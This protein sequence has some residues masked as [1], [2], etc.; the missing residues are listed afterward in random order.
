VG[1]GQPAR[2]ADWTKVS[3]LAPG[4]E[5]TVTTDSR[6]LLLHFVSA[7]ARGVVLLNVS[8][9]PMSYGAQI[10]LARMLVDHPT[11]FA[12]DAT[13]TIIDHNYRLTPERFVERDRPVATRSQLIEYVD[14]RI[15]RK[16][17]RNGK[18]GSYAAR[19]SLI[20]GLVGGAVVFAVIRSGCAPSPDCTGAGVAY[21]PIGAGFGTLVGALIGYS[22]TRDRSIVVYSAP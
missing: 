20:G 8:A 12:L 10:T 13:T 15:V 6:T 19:G 21:T 16:I 22:I 9:V 5:V 14:R 4:T 3:Q 7:D 17:S 18:S 1:L 11:D 2:D